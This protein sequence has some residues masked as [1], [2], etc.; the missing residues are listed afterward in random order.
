VQPVQRGEVAVVAMVDGTSSLRIDV[1]DRTDKLIQSVSVMTIAEAKTLVHDGVPAAA[2][3]DRIAAAN[4][5]LAALHGLHDL[6][7]MHPLEL[8][9]TDGDRHLA[10]G[11]GLDIDWDHDHLHVFHHNATQAIVTLDGT[12]WLV[13]EHKAC[14]DC[15]PCNHP[16]FLAGVYHAPDINSVVVDIGYHGTDAC[17]E[18]GDQQHVVV[19]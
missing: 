19:W 1:R 4:R 10:I 5:E 12:R 6:V 8:Q 18:P 14:P 16:A 9:A 2:L 15:A 3:Q 13:R 7:A 17:L 11:D